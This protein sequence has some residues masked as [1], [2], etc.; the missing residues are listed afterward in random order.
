METKKILKDMSIKYRT[1]G[2]RVIVVI[3]Q[4]NYLA[5]LKRQFNQMDPKNS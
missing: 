1:N 3:D 4:I 2:F 5:S